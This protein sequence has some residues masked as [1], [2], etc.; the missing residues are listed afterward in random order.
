MYAAGTGGLGIAASGPRGGRGLYGPDSEYQHR[1]KESFF[2][3]TRRSSAGNVDVSGQHFQNV[4]A[5]QQ[6]AASATMPNAAAPLQQQAGGANTGGV[7]EVLQ[8]AIGGVA[9]GAIGNL[10]QRESKGSKR[11]SSLKQLFGGDR[12][13]RRQ[14]SSSSSWKVRRRPSLR[15]GNMF[16][17]PPLC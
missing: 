17:D 10:D 1:H 3:E 11:R 7:P 14:S 5:A 12:T 16:T 6:P 15:L 4:P 13:N 8:G 9:G 2:P